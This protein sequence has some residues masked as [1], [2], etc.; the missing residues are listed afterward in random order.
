MTETVFVTNRSETAL[1]DG[2][3]GIFY[4]FLRGKPVEIPID[5]AKHVF[6]YGMENKEPCLARLGW[7]RFHSD[8]N[9]GIERLN[10]FEITSQPAQQNRSLPSA[11]SV[12]P[13]RVEK[14]A[15]GKVNQRA[16]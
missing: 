2:Y 1:T 8:L 5:V 16:A 7:I 6:G 13:L 15:G 14:H 12:V 11:I 4:E 3:G 10:K 9:S